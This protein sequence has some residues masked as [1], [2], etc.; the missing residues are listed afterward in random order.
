MDGWVDDGWMDEWLGG[1]MDACVDGWMSGLM[2]DGWMD[3]WMDGGWMGEYTA[4]GSI[5]VVEYYTPMKRKEALTQAIVCMDLEHRMLTE[6][7]RHR[8]TYSG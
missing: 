7:S 2:M 1:W 3:G 5:R 4:W 6:R 8:R